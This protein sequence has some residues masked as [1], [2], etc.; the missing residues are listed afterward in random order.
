MTITDTINALRADRDATIVRLLNT[1]AT[2][3]KA[4]EAVGSSLSKVLDVAKRY[5][6]LRQMKAVTT[7][8][9]GE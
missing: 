5:G 1:G 2:Y 7:A 3:Q 8:G 4:A 9:E 6:L